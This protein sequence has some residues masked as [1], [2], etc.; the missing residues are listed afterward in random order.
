MYLIALCY[1][2]YLVWIVVLERERETKVLNPVLSQTT[3]HGETCLNT[4]A[5]SIMPSIYLD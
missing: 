5:I 2:L 4:A 3:E 1:L